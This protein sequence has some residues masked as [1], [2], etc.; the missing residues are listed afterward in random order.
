MGGHE[1]EMRGSW[2]G[3]G[4]IPPNLVRHRRAL[5]AAGLLAL[6]V[7]A[8]L[9]RLIPLLRGGGLVAK[10]GHDDAVYFASAVAF[11]E[12]R[13]PYH[14][15]FILHPPGILY[16]LSPFAATDRLIGDAAAFALARLA[17][18]ALGAVN[19]VLV[20]LVARR[21]G[22]LAAACSATLYAVWIVPASW[23]R[24]TYLVAPQATLLLVALLVLGGRRPP[25]VTPRR[26][27]V[28][29]ACIG[30]AGIIQL[31]A[32]IPA[33]IIF[34]WLVLAQRRTPARLLR[35]AA[36]YVAGGVATAVVLV[37]PFLLTVGER[38][39]QLTVLGQLARTGSFGPGRVTRLRFLEGLQMSGHL[40]S[41]VPDAVVVLAFLALAALVAVVVW[42]RW[43]IR[44]WAAL[45]AGQT[46]FLMITPVFFG[47]YG[48]WVAPVATLSI[49]ITAAAIIGWIGTAGRRLAGAA[50]RVAGTVYALGL[51]VLLVVTLRPSGTR[52]MVTPT[53]PGLADA[54]CVTADEVI[55]LVT[56]ET[57]RRDLERGCPFMPN[58]GSLSHVINLDRG[59]GSVRRRDLQEYQVEMAR[60]FGGSDAALFLRLAKDGF[61]PETLASIQ[62]ELP[63]ERQIGPV[64]VLLRSEP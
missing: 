19:T 52:P 46:A 31:W 2:P 61:R 36:G 26:A 18:M 16:L 47:H 48:G 41:R 33:A 55:L 12:G 59:D 56:S 60:Y 4:L 42:R 54:R 13:L 39:L 45:L 9:A 7:V 17:F 29:G 34:G 11:V 14:D 53:S 5:A 35:V 8:F 27:V 32:A 43:E 30:A 24:T 28:A 63:I 44:L 25:E 21:A 58:P 20:A 51:V 38:M 50:P 22:L 40:A 1:A 49:G 62:A 57:L 23:E 6:A 3:V 10:L 64:T 15:F 37:L